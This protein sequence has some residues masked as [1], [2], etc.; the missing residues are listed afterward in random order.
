M[1]FQR[2]TENLGKKARNLSRRTRRSLLRMDD[3]SS[4]SVSDGEL[5]I[6]GYNSDEDEEALARL[7]EPK[8]ARSPPIMLQEYKDRKRIRKYEIN[9]AA[10]RQ[11]ADIQNRNDN[12]VNQMIQNINV[13][14]GTNVGNTDPVIRFVIR[15]IIN[16]HGLT[17]KS[18]ALMAQSRILLS[19]L[20][21]AA[22]RRSV[23]TGQVVYSAGRAALAALQAFA[24]R[25]ASAVASR[26]PSASASIF[27][28]PNPQVLQG[29]PLGVHPLDQARPRF[30]DFGQAAS[31][32]AASSRADAQLAREL[33]MNA[34]AQLARELSSNLDAERDAFAGFESA[35][36]RNAVSAPASAP[37]PPPLQD[38]DLECAICFLGE[39]TDRGPLGYVAVH[40]PSLDNRATGY[41]DT[42]HP[43]RF[44]EA[45][46]RLCPGDKCPMCRA[47]PVWGLVRKQPQGGGGL[48]KYRSKSRSKSKS[49]TRRLRKSRNKSRKS[50][51]SCKSRKPRSSSRRK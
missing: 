47:K 28:R 23:N 18:I 10:L 4:D 39:G 14:L 33:S 2:V 44:H 20:G 36:A 48:K 11:S 15:Q 43:D 8:R 5:G 13:A 45:C 26:L 49:K 32:R 24:S 31:S 35:R 17:L 51:K 25:G 27:S 50:R 6:A 1:S 30:I 21:E 9:Q 37:P 34:D 19:A 42:G 12:A 29:M 41:I 40:N 38:Q 22:V 16:A 46:L 7:Q 3:V